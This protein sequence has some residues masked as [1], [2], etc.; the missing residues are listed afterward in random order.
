MISALHAI[1]FVYNLF[2]HMP[3]YKFKCCEEC[4]QTEFT[5]LLTIDNYTSEVQCPCKKGIAKRVF[6]SFAHKDGFTKQQK[7]AGVKENR[8]EATAYT[9]H[10]RELRKK[11]YPPGSREAVSNEL[12][13]GKEGLDGITNIADIK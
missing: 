2:I 6:S 7:E 12:W 11:E 5:L 13:T 8:I 4:S 1:H 10:Q 9:K 3:L